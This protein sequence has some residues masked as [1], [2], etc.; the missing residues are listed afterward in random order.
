M[1]RLLVLLA[2][3]EAVT[4]A[5]ADDSTEEPHW[6]Y[7]IQATELNN[8]CKGPD[9]WPGDCQKTHQSP[10]NIVT[11][12]ARLDK[13][14][15][16]FSF[17]G[18]NKKEKRVVTNNGH[19]VM[20]LLG[21]EVYIAEGGLTSQYQATQLHLHW[22]QEVDRGSE[23]TVDGKH[24][25]M[26]MHIVHEKKTG[27]SSNKNVLQNPND[28]IAVLAFLVEVGDKINNG[29]QPLVNALTSIS[30]PNM[31][32]TVNEI[33]LM[34]MLP[35][36]EKLR[37]YFRYSGSLTTP[38][39]DE[40]VIWTVFKEPIKLHEHQFEAFSQK[41]FYD[42]EE[43]LTMKDNVRPVQQLGDRQ[44]YKSRAPGQL[45]SLPLP[46]LLVSTF[47]YLMVSLLR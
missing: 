45:L 11:T 38:T 40:T 12:T 37:H 47:A 36:E 18:Y 46:T 16:P 24:F 21:T 20:V 2:L 35:N 30:K 44:V 13:N 34:D 42:Q 41:L 8:N 10:I 6:C 33:N 17:F 32:T 43:T 29:F 26:E 9:H 25:A 19:S 5:Y 23:H 22:S 15:G 3:A 27:T 39:C 31:S 14:L 7:E 1:Q 4:L 28:K